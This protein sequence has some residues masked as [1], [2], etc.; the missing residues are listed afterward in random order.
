MEQSQSNIDNKSFRTRKKEKKKKGNIPAAAASSSLVTASVGMHD[1]FGFSR[2]HC[3]CWT[4]CQAGLDGQK[5]T[6]MDKDGRGNSDGRGKL[7]GKLTQTASFHRRCQA[8]LKCLKSTQCH[9]RCYRGDLR[10][11]DVDGG[12]RTWKSVKSKKVLVLIILVI[13]F[14]H[15]IKI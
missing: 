13:V 14:N 5:W 6:K 9:D 12:V 1:V 3:V 7:K 10:K 2:N 11:V 15:K 8:M 4:Y